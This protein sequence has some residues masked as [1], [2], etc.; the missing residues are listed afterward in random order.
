MASSPS[1]DLGISGIPSPFQ[2]HTSG[3]E[4]HML[5]LPFGVTMTSAGKEVSS[6]KPT[7]GKIHLQLKFW[8]LS[9]N[10]LASRCKILGLEGLGCW[11][12]SGTMS[13]P[14]LMD[15]DTT[16]TFPDIMVTLLKG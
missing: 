6:T 11:L 2:L 1:T 3:Q 8:M 12:H 14:I 9:V 4:T 7:A 13:I 15:L 16:F 10:L 5:S